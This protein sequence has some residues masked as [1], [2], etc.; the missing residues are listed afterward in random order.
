MAEVSP[1]QRIA[2]QVLASDTV[3][4]LSG[5]LRNVVIFE[6]DRYHSRIPLHLRPSHFP[7]KGKTTTVKRSCNCCTDSSHSCC[8]NRSSSSSLSYEISDLKSSMLDAGE[9]D[10][11]DL[12]L[13][14]EAESDDKR[15][16]VGT[17]S[18]DMTG[19]SSRADIMLCIYST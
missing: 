11:D 10:V 8:A 13:K 17:K 6:Y 16:W 9:T 1:A 12:G 3:R 19:T 14:S 5:K 15:G 4:K 2:S 18:R 7:K